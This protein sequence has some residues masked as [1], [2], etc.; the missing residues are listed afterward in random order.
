MT[1]KFRKLSEFEA[2]MVTIRIVIIELVLLVGFL[3]YVV[4]HLAGDFK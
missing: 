2:L 4:R 1:N 3:W